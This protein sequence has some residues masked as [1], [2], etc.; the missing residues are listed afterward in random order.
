MLW[1]IGFWATI[2]K[3]SI[4]EKIRLRYFLLTQQF[5]WYFYLNILQA[6]TLK[7]INYTIFLK[8]LNKI[9]HVHLNILF[10]L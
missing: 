9:F 6:V 3:K 8:E 1:I 7:L 2:S 4:L 10:K 5:F